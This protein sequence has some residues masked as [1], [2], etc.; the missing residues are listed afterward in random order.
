MSR[1]KKR[2]GMVDQAVARKDESKA[3][4]MSNHKLIAR[5][6]VFNVG[7]DHGNQFRITLF[8]MFD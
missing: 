1:W 7:P 8:Q 2:G 4:V 5:K 3:C 6:Y